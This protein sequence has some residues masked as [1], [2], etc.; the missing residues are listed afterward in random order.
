[1]INSL[2][3]V[4]L[5]YFTHGPGSSYRPLVYCTYLKYY[6]LLRQIYFKL[7][8]TTMPSTYQ[9]LNGT[10]LTKIKLNKSVQ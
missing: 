6:P 5:H 8:T 4:L 10:Y 3:D 9:L 2:Y 1:M 7:E